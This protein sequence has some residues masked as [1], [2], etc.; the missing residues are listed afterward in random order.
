LRSKSVSIDC[1]RF[2][3]S[4]SD[5]ARVWAVLL[6]LLGSC[7]YSQKHPAVPI[8]IAGGIVGFGGCEM[9]SVRVSTCG[10]IGGIVALGL[11][12]LAALVTLFADTE[13]HQLPPDEE[14]L[15]SGAVR[16]RTHTLL[17]P[18]LAIDAGVIDS[19]QPVIDSVQPV[20]GAAVDAQ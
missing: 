6:A 16:V 14:M 10:E 3:A 8:G 17:P 2:G 12:G 18:G 19:V 15:P 4:R 1:K 7:E 11:G 9:D 5:A 13:D 20:D